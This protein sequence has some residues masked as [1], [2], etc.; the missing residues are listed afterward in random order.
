MYDIK[1][2]SFESQSSPGTIFRQDL[3]QEMSFVLRM[4]CWD[5]G[6]WFER[7]LF[8][9]PVPTFRDHALSL[10]HERPRHDARGGTVRTYDIYPEKHDLHALAGKNREVCHMFGDQNAVA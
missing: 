8:R 10:L 7:D 3:P 2:L 5:S 9:K 1:W 4:T 6:I